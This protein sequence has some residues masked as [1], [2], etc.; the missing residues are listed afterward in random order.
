MKS[1]EHFLSWEALSRVVLMGLGIFLM[2][3][4]ISAVVII[5]VSLVISASL[6]PI[7]QKIHLKTKLPILLSILVVIL[8]LLIPFFIIG[9]TIIPSFS[10]QYSELISHFNNALKN[11]PIISN[12]LTDFDLSQYLQS[13]YSF[14]V[15]HSWDIINTIIS[16]TSIIILTIYFIFDYERLLKLFLSIFPYKEKAKLK[17][18]LGEVAR[19]TGQYIR[20]NVLISIIST[21]VVYIS[22]IALSV[23]F[24]LPLAIFSG[25]LDLL[26]MVGYSI[27]AIPSLLIAFSITP[28]KGFILLI[29]FVVY[30]QVENAFISPVIYNKALNLYPALAFLAVIIGAS[31]FGILGAFLALPIAASIPAVIDYHQNYVEKHS[32][33]KIV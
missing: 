27:G 23:P 8:L 4:A 22:L 30:Q 9:I 12:S 24:A 11:I 10:V 29:I 18:I 32:K 3:K 2:W 33:D 7:V 5:L 17:E 25:I 16:I 20:G 13:H 26:P 28:L 21:V 1:Q 14:F 19:V 6:F 15:S 31:L